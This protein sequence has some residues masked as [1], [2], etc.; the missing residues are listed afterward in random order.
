MHQLWAGTLQLYDEHN[1][2]S[3]CSAW[4][5]SF[6]NKACALEGKTITIELLA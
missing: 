3:Q 1:K 5:L 2:M 6:L 4:P